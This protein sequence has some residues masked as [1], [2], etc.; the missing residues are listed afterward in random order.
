MGIMAVTPVR[1]DDDRR[2]ARG[3][4]RRPIFGARL[5]AARLRTIVL[6]RAYACEIAT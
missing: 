3:P 1:A 6:R 4:R 5:W 2:V